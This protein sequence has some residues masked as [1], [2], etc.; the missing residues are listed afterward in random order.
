MLPTSCGVTQGS[1]LGPLLFTLCIT[2]LCSIN[3]SHT[4]DHHLYVDNIQIY[5]FVATSGTCR[6]LNPHRDYLQDVS[7]WMDNCKLKLN[8]HKI[9]FLIIDSPT[10]RRKLDVF[11]RH[12]F[13][14]VFQTCVLSVKSRSN[15]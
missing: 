2:P 3:K 5:I 6:S 14:S 7:L 10:Q 12:I 11:F 15:V 8:A 1:I 13:E 4:L 9:E